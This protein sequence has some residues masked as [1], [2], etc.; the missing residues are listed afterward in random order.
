MAKQLSDYVHLYLGC[1]LFGK[2]DDERNQRGFLTGVTNGGTECEI[3]FLEEDGINVSE[4]PAWND[5]ADVKLILRPLYDMT[6]EEAIEYAQ[7]YCGKPIRTDA[8]VTIKE[9]ENNM[10]NVTIEGT[11]TGSKLSLFPGGALGDKAEA[12]RFLLSKGFDLFG[13]IKEN[14]VHDK[15]K[16]DK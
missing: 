5:L 16:L 1:E 6:K 14:L 9:R 11:L 13:L 15:T 12:I 3:Q 8:T 7:F 4:I 2:R 10:V